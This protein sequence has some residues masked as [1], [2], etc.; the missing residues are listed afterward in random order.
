[1]LSLKNYRGGPR[2]IV[3]LAAPRTQI[4]DV[5]GPF[6]VFVR[7]AELFVQ[8]HPEGGRPYEVVLASTT[9]R[10]AVATNCGLTLVGGE[11]F[12]SLREPIDTLLIAGGS[13]LETAGRD[14]QLRSWL[15]KIAPRSGAS[16][17][18]AR[19][20]SCLPLPVFWTANAQPRIG[21]GPLNSRRSVRPPPLILTRSSYAMETRTPPPA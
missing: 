5:A 3:F 2:R 19:E 21:S 9:M 18:S 1:M 4:L 17:P 13:G 16:D 15:R 14:E 11:T 7:A 12:R 20:P 8:Q 6:Q 10:K